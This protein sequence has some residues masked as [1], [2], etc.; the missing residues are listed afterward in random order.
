MWNGTARTEDPSFAPKAGGRDVR[1][2]RRKRS[3]LR[4]LLDIGI[5][6]LGLVT[7]EESA[8]HGLE[9]MG[10]EG[11]ARIAVGAAVVRA[12][13]ARYGI[14]LVGIEGLSWT[15]IASLR[16][17]LGLRSAFGTGPGYLDV[18]FGTVQRIG[19]DRYTV[20]ARVDARWAKGRRLRE[21]RI[22]LRVRDGNATVTA[23]RPLRGF[24]EPF[25]ERPYEARMISSRSRQY[26]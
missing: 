21:S 13:M 26:P 8:W 23:R 15:E 19:G 11:R 12:E 5:V 24:A 14:S 9:A 2:R 6:V 4:R 20:D 18:R 22:E 3:F 25:S 16:R 10:P 7:V 17:R 1:R